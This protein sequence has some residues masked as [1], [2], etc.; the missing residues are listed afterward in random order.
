M[1]NPKNLIFRVFFGIFAKMRF[2]PQKVT[3]W[4]RKVLFKFSKYVSIKTVKKASI[5]N[6]LP[7]SIIENFTITESCYYDELKDILNDD[8]LKENKLLKLAQFSKSLA[9]L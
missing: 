8:C 4:R 3:L 1:Q 9:T 5:S 7:V 6:G 2:F